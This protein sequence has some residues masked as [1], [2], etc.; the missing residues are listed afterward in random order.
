[1][2]INEKAPPK[3]ETLRSAFSCRFC[4]YNSKYNIKSQL[5][6]DI[7]AYIK[8]NQLI[9]KLILLINRGIIVWTDMI[10]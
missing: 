9:K 1:M 7:L 5:K 3:Y 8:M 4:N 10:V 6:S 2:A